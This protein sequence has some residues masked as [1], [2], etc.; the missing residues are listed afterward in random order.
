MVRQ[1][2]WHMPSRS[3]RLV[4]IYSIALDLAFRTFELISLARGRALTRR[5][6]CLLAMAYAKYRKL[7]K[8]AV[9]STYESV[10][11]L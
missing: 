7:S 6:K 9:K 3:R 2:I 10:V 1:N 8:Q 4:Q 11:K 5:R